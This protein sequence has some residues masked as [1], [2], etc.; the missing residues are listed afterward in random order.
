VKSTSVTD[1]RVR[2]TQSRLRDALISLI[3]EKSY[4]TVVVNEILQRADVGRSAFYAHFATKHALLASG[5]DHVLHAATARQ[6][7]ANLGPLGKVVRFS[8]PFFEFVGQ[9][10]DTTNLKT[11]RR[12]RA[13]VHS[14][15]RKLLVDRVRREIAEMALPL[16]KDAL[17]IPADL[18]AEHVAGT[19][20][21]VLNWWVDTQSELSPQQTDDVFLSLVGPVLVA[22][23]RG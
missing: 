16:K 9:C 17:A 14:H 22:A 7:L 3:H 2:K 19:F 4:D 8:L 21:L 5:I 15:L 11:S 12:G 20:V 13:V 6:P 1:A 18:L 23:A 10:R